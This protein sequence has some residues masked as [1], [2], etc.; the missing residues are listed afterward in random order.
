MA[1]LR[2]SHGFFALTLVLLLLTLT[3]MA[4]IGPYQLALADWHSIRQN[5]ANSQ[6][7]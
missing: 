3:A 6:D 2:K 5:V 4:L 1:D 7:S